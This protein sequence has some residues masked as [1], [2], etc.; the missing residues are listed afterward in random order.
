MLETVSN[1]RSYTKIYREAMRVRDVAYHPD[2][3]QRT[4]FGY[5]SARQS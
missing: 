5:R 1:E 3:V 2:L 4:C